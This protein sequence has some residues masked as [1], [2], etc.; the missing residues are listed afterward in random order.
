LNGDGGDELFAGYRRYIPFSKVDFFKSSLVRKNLFQFSHK[1]MPSTKSKMN[2]LGYFKRL[3]FLGSAPSQLSTYLRSTTDIFEGYYD[4]FFFSTNLSGSLMYSEL[5]KT[6]NSDLSGLQK[7]MLLD[8][9]NILPSILLV[10][11][12]IATMANSQEG[13]SRFFIQRSVGIYPMLT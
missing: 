7:L 4:K 2:K 9:E 13:R 11:L 6:A 8:F 10:K 3:F 5:M 12:D 1:L